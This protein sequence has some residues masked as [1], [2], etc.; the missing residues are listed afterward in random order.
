MSSGPRRA[1]LAA[2]VATAGVACA[3][4]AAAQV[5]APQQS[6]A[7]P[8]AWP[9]G[10]G[11]ALTLYG[12]WRSGGSFTDT[13]TGRAVSTDPSGSF[14]ASI[15]R[16][17][18]AMRQVQVFVSHQSSRL[19]LPAGGTVP[20]GVTH[21]HLGGTNYFEGPAGR[22]PYLSGGLGVSVFSPGLSGL[23]T[24]FRPSISLGIGWQVPLGAR[25]SLR[26]E[27]RGYAVLVNSSGDFF[28][29]GGCVV[30]LRG[31]TYTQGEVLLGVS[32][33]F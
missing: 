30:S 12:G 8:S 31:D 3:P 19:A 24:E 10:E 16:R 18:D 14:A 2:M 33:G 5:S 4:P 28:C 7:A 20:V 32:I 21:L 15:E 29:S 22:G 25:A 6:A 27:A 13:S 23:S 9:A 17:L 11:A 26:L 1:A